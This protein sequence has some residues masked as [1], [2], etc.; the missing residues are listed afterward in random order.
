MR[1]KKFTDPIGSIITL[2]NVDGQD[3]RM[4]VQQTVR[5]VA[6]LLDDKTKEFIAVQRAVGRI[7]LLVIINRVDI[8]TV[9]ESDLER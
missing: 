2:K 6:T 8:V 7:W 5:D 9:Q 4:Y 3:R 1:T